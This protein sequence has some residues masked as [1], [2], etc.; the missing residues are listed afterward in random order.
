MHTH[1]SLVWG[2]VEG[3]I[4]PGGQKFVAGM[5]S[6]G[7]TDP[8]GLKVPAGHSV[9]SSQVPPKLYV[10][11]GHSWQ[12][13]FTAPSPYPGRQAHVS[14]LMK[15]EPGSCG[16]PKGPWP[17]GQ[18]WVLT[19]HWTGSIAPAGPV[20]PKPQGVQGSRPSKPVPYVPAGHK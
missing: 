13:L 18:A 14:G 7:F 8:A 10:P 16:I 9:H 12:D 6:A 5:Q 17:L 19:P 15:S 3:R 4:M 1:S 2:A 11:G 20:R